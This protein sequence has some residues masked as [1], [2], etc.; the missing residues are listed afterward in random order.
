MLNFVRLIFFEFLK[1]RALQFYNLLE[2]LFA[3][4]FYLLPQQTKIQHQGNELLI[5]L[6]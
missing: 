2:A 3:S 4:P 1:S 5:R 6:Q